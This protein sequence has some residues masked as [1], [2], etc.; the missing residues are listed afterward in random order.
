MSCEHSEGLLSQIFS[1]KSEDVA[2]FTF[3]QNEKYNK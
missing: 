2:N 3:E 1:Q